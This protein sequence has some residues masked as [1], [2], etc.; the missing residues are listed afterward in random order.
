MADGSLIFETGLDNS[1][2]ERDL[3]KL[4]G[5]L[6]QTGG[7]LEQTLAQK[8]AGAFAEFSAQALAAARENTGAGFA[9]TE[10]AQALTAGLVESR[11]EAVA[12]VKA[13][14]SAKIA[15]FKEESD[16]QTREQVAALR[17][18]A[19]TVGSYGKQLIQNRIAEVQAEA[20][21]A[22][23]AYTA[24][25]KELMGAAVEEIRTEAAS[26]QSLL[27]ETVGALAES[28]ESARDRLEK[29]QEKLAARLAGYGDWTDT[30]TPD[31]ALSAMEMNV[32]A[33][34]R[35]GELLDE[36]Q[37][38]GASDAFLQTFAGLNVDQA[39]EL[40][41]NLT[42]LGSVR[43]D[44]YMA[45]WEEQQ[46][47]A[48]AIAERFYGEQLTHLDEEFNQK[49]VGV[50]NRLPEELGQMGQAAV[51]G[52]LAGM[53]SKQAEALAT[54]GDLA[55][56]IKETLREAFEIH[57]PSRWMRREIGENLARGLALGF[58]GGLSG[59]EGALVQTALDGF[60]QTA[61]ELGQ[62]GSGW[63][64]SPAAPAVPET[65]THTVVKEKVVGVQFSGS[66]A[67][68]ARLLRPQLLREN[69]RAGKSF[70]EGGSQ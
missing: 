7:A 29:G 15:A 55:A 27:D 35:Y 51:E 43:F 49:L 56:G 68:I 59:A 31:D 21:N 18:Q 45:A 14:S 60:A 54:A 8:I 70:A 48:R 26:A 66:G 69:I 6:A 2:L 40:G 64:R 22:Q 9:G 4:E 47:K 1:G 63:E 42:A 12:R 38:K 28:Y 50:M 5:Q 53:A 24:A 67:E 58:A 57:S 34:E 19:K 11:D 23:T 46:E 16:R 3:Q 25:A 17:L 44:R 10:V 52:F 39:L 32:R 20:K 33:L 37:E 13:L 65:R 30:A 41:E 62:A 36:L 61:A